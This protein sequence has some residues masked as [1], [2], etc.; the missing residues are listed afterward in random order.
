MKSTRAAWLSHLQ[1]GLALLL[2]CLLSLQLV[3]ALRI[4]VMAVLAPQST[5]FQRSEVWR[6]LVDKGQVAWDQ[7]WVDLPQISQNLQ[8]AVVASEDAGFVDHGGVE[9]DAIEKAWGKNQ[10]AADKAA[11]VRTSKKKPGVVLAPK[12]V[13]GSTITQQL[14]KNLFLS[15]ER[16]TLRKVQELLL[17]FMLEGL[18]DKQRIL[19][20]YLNSVEWGEGVFGA[21]AAAQHY[22]RSDAKRLSAELQLGLCQQPCRCHRAA[23][24]GRG[25]AM[26][27]TMMS[28][29]TEEIAN[30]A[31]RLVVEEGMEYAQAKRKAAQNL[32]NQIGGRPEL[33]SNEQLEDAV[34]E[35]IALFNA[36]TQPA[37][38]GA[39]REVALLWMQR[40][41]DFHPHLSGAAWRGTATRL[42]AVH[43][44]LYCDDTKA[45]EIML[46]NAG[47]DYDV[48]SL[49]KPGRREPLPVLSLSSRSAALGE[50]V[51]V[52][53]LLHDYDD[54]R[55]ALKP[56]AQGRAWRGNLIALQRVMQE[57][58]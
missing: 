8:L 38:L 36:D 3:F 49:D 27:A 25:T 28:S 46:I 7:Q 33:P 55:G 5:S 1:R 48:G 19:E 13:G 43:L 45:A 2:L 24:G 52:H 57:Q 23:H 32:K 35:H 30:L 53:L 26:M 10:R 4:G 22:F 39:L 11:K 34:R 42:S 6:L 58:P 47:E 51:T 50:L 16:T 56:D 41:A 20:I 9:W 17:S 40:L 14:A 44:D 29:V 37:E 15:G 54:L 18:L 21:Q 31:A 12:V